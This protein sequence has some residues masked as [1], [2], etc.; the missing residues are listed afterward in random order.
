APPSGAG[1]RTEGR[2][3]AESIPRRNVLCVLWLQTRRHHR[4]RSPGAPHDLLV[5]PEHA[6]RQIEACGWRRQPVALL[7]GAGRIVL[8]VEIERA[9]AIELQRVAIADSKALDGVGGKVA[10]IVVERERPE[11]F[12]RRRLAF[13]EVQAVTLSTL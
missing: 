7:V 13:F 12:D 2:C 1:S 11:S 8:N 9:I 6:Q 10:V 4:R 5:R 3:P